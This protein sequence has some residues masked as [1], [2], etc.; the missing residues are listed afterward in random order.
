[1]KFRL[2]ST[3]A[4]GYKA[5]E[6][7]RCADQNLFTCSF[8]KTM[9]SYGKKGQHDLATVL[10]LGGRTYSTQTAASKRRAPQPQE[11][12]FNISLF[13]FFN[14]FAMHSPASNRV[15]TIIPDFRPLEKAS[16]LNHF[17]A[18]DACV[19]LQTLYLG[20]V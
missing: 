2:C 1:M 5:S 18:P 8:P 14:V 12:P 3:L 17:I 7:G 10:A 19:Q 9:N 6:G 11:A 13:Y 15:P 20:N 16:Y 4:S